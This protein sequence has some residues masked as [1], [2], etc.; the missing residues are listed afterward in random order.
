MSKRAII[1]ILSIT[2]LFFALSFCSASS[3]EIIKDPKPTHFEKKYTQLIKMKSVSFDLKGDK[4]NFIAKIY[5]TTI[6][7]NGNLYLY[8]VPQAKIFKF[9]K[10]LRLISKFENQG[11]GQGE[12]AAHQAFPKEIE[13]G[14]DNLLYMSAPGNQ[15]IHIYNLHGRFLGGH[16]VKYPMIYK[17]IV[18]SKGEFYIPTTTDD[19]IIDVFDKDMV[20]KSTLLNRSEFDR[21]IFR[22]P[23]YLSAMMFTRPSY[24][25]SIF[26]DLLPDDRLIIIITNEPTLYLLDE[27]KL[28]KKVKIMPDNALKI[29]KRD[30]LPQLIN[31]E[32]ENS[33]FLFIRNFFL[34]EDN[35]EYFYLQFSK[36]M[37]KN[38]DTVYKFSITGKLLGVF[39]V[40]HKREGMYLNFFLK[41]NN[42]FYATDGENII[43]FKEKKK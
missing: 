38:M 30:Y 1:T 34:D 25:R 32:D 19:G 36:D 13:V 9:S 5:S 17:P 27:C 35:H 16:R 20:L 6:D 26:Y 2:F 22:K 7:K 12:L 33:F 24:R 42:I 31:D 4:E 39:Y 37:K 23:G 43:I 41:K 8:D 14:N 3:I 10:N 15:K 28:M 11:R 21:F 40:E 29:F 18:S